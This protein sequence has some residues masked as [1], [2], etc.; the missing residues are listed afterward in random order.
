MH[1]SWKQGFIFSVVFFVLLVLQSHSPALAGD[2][3]LTWNAPTTNTDG[4]PLTDLAGFKV[5][6][7]TSSGIYSTT[8]DA[9]NQTTYTV[10]GLGT[11]TF[12]FTVTAYDSSGNESGFSNEGSKTF[13]DT[14]PPV[15]SAIGAGSITSS[16]ATITW[17]TNEASDTQVQ[18]G[19]TT[20]YG[21]STTLNSTKV[22][23]HS[24][25]LTGLLAATLY[26]YRVLSRDAAGNLA[27]SGDNT[28]TTLTPPDT[29]PPVISGIASSSITTSGATISWTTN[30]ASDTQ[31]QYGI[32]TAYGSST[33]LNSTKVTSHSQALTGLLDTTLYHY[34]VLSRDAAGNL[35]TSSDS[36]FT[37]LTPPDT[38]PPVISGI[39]SSNITTSGATIA[40]T[41]DELSDTQVQYGTTTAYGSSTTLNST[42]VTSHSQ[43]LTGLQ[44]STLYH[45]RVLSRDAAGNLATSGDGTFTTS[46]P[47]DTTPP[48]ISGITASNITN[49]GAIITW[50]TNEA[51]SSQVEYGTTTSYG[52]STTLNSTL[53]T[54]HSVT[55]TGLAASTTYHYR[56]KSADASSNL[57]TSG[58]NTFTTS[59]APDT[60]PPVI[61]IVASGNIQ[62][63]S[64]NITWTTNE[65]SSSQVEYGTTTAYGSS[66][67]L[68][69]TMVTGHS[70]AL[71]GLSASTTYHFRVKSADAASNLATSGDNT[72]TTPAAPDTTPPV[73][74]N[75]GSGNITS[76]GAAISWTTNELS[77][78]QIQYGT[79]TAY[80]SSTTV[81]S[82][83]VTSHGQSLTGL[84]AS[85][86]YHYRVLSRDAS[87]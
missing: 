65:A 57:A 51:S 6:Y 53:V 20:A 22:T 85:T 30:E 14:T 52:S 42:K 1:T 46:T 32:T 76:S 87:G 10:T 70:V 74:S 45:Y 56:V 29:T 5:Y 3:S 8:I 83:L 31:V 26:H 16:G 40:W 34:R 17:T 19:I 18:Y 84:Q 68:N 48:V 43:A 61:S 21:S 69:S 7:G 75:I 12:Y 49:T 24:Q 78:T 25:A 28:F 27:A 38:T 59:A 13:A 54:S 11:G 55:L 67:T 47:P 82:T 37:T 39:A 72:F 66:T 64:A 80:G 36:T 86:A 4:S 62:F 79:T 71:T 60:T 2:A 58:D 35:A 41:T 15:I 77:D 73:I 23:S 63:N 33:T 50:A 44:A 9:G 81:N